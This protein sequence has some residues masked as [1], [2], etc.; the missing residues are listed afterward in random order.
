MR[1]T[2]RPLGQFQANSY[3]LHDDRSDQA[4]VIDPGSPDPWLLEQIKGLKV[5]YILLTHA[6]FDHIGGLTA[7]KEATGAPILIHAAAA[8][9]LTNPAL[10]ASARWPD[11]VQLAVALVADRL[12]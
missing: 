2:G 7:V 4:L 5:A 11:L 3:I 10:N 12:R 9:W 1:V 8:D 6:H